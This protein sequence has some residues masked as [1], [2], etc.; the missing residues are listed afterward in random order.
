[1][2]FMVLLELSRIPL[3]RLTHS[4]LEEFH[5]LLRCGEASVPEEMLPEAGLV[6]FA[7]EKFL[8]N[9]DVE[10]AGLADFEDNLET[11]LLVNGG[12]D[13]RSSWAKASGSTVTDLDLHD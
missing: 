1:M 13:T 6:V 2:E 5:N 4:F 8:L 7:D 12:C 9:K 10:L 11:E 3:V